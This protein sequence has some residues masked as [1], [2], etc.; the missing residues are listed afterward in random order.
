MTMCAYRRFPIAFFFVCLAGGALP[1]IQGPTNFGKTAAGENVDIY[2]LTNGK[3][4]SAKV[5]TLGRSLSISRSPTSR[6][7]PT[8]SC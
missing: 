5:M 3:G 2:T 1:D 4:M 7:R 6:A 8:A